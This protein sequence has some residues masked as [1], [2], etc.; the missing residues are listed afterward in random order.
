MSSIL[1]LTRPTQAVA[2][3]VR[4]LPRIA[5]SLLGTGQVGA[6]LLHQLAE[7]G[8]F[9]APRLVALANSRR[10]LA[11]PDGI[12]PADALSR[13]WDEGGNPGLEAPLAAVTNTAADVRVMVDAT[14]AQEVALGRTPVVL[15]AAR[16]SPGARIYRAGPA[17]GPVGSRRGTQ[18][19]DRRAR[20]R[21]AARRGRHRR[22]G[23]GSPA[24]ARH[25]AGRVPRPSRRARRDP[26]TPP[27]RRCRNR[28]D[29]AVRRA[30]AR[31]SARH[32]APRGAAAGSSLRAAVRRRQPLRVHHPPLPRAAAGRA[33][34]RSRSGG[35]RA[36][37]AGGR[38]R[39]WAAGGN[40][41]LNAPADAERSAPCFRPD[42]RFHFHWTA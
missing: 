19:P 6:A 5:V 37:A 2:S 23:P 22:G 20:R 40:T 35:D 1:P 34:P 16:G 13:L 29:A 32:R 38:V 18:A 28:P 21:K 36:G 7:Q 4:K 11:A 39:G 15:L 12:A 10:A 3:R 31:G 17:R 8:G 33:R 24:I 42:R 27:P 41:R 26:R 25:S 9:A 30:L 14:A